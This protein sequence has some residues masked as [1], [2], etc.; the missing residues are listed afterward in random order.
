MA[1]E[2]TG[3]Y[4]LP[5]TRDAVWSALND[6]EFLQRCIPGCESFEKLSETEFAAIVRLAVGPVKARFKGKVRLQDLNPPQSYTI[7]GEGQ[8]GIAG[9]AKGNAAVMLTDIAEGTNLSYRAQAQIGGK[10]AQ[11]GQR[12]VAGTVKKIADLFFANCVA[13]LAQKRG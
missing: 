6:P 1:L 11:L 2:M 4:I 8:G 3:E 5:L 7:V 13:A 9:F 10:I 12:L